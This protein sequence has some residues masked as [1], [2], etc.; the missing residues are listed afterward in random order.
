M[1]A[2]T[3]RKLPLRIVLSY[4]CGIIGCSMLVNMISVILFYIYVPTSESGLP[5]LIFQG[6]VFGV[7]SL[8]ALITSGGRFIDAIYDPFIA[9]KSDQSRHK[10]GRRIPFMKFAALPAAVF[11]VLVFVPLTSEESSLNAFWLAFTLIVF[12]VSA[13]TYMIPY[14][15]MLPELART[16]EEKIK[17]STWQSVG[18]V[19]GIGL[20]SNAFNVAALFQQH[21]HM[22]KLQ[23]LQ[24]T[25]GIF[26]FLALIFLLIPVFTIKEREWCEGEATPISLMKALKQTMSN[27]GFRLYLLADFAFNTSITIIQAGLLYFV[28]ILLRLPEEMGNKLMMVLVGVSFVFYPI[29]GPVTRKIGMKVIIAGSLIMLGCVFVCLAMLGKID[30]SPEVQ[31]YTAIALAAI[32]M[33]TLNILPMALLAEIIER[34][35][36][37]T[38]VN[39]EAMY[40]A[41]R[42]FFVKLA[43]TAGFALFASLLIYGKDVGN[44][45]GIRLTGYVGCALCVAAGL[46]FFRFK[47]KN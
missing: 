13:T 9:Q 24:L 32:P 20:A 23:S 5:T 6:T 30:W 42:Y 18:Y 26:C 44:D 14:L 36:Q 34:D 22:E 43:Q 40:F 2:E 38:K 33:A 29:I 45:F 25:I 21:F 19:V 8:I 11:C 27:K 3:A 37:E 15:A 17:L 31:I 7:V 46:Y 10:S 41:V 16:S 12:Y 39:K 1:S 4:S 28:T 35:S 47:Q